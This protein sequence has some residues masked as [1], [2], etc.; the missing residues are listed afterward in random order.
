GECTTQGIGSSNTASIAVPSGGGAGQVSA[1][2]IP[3]NEN[4]VVAPAV[5]GTGTTTALNIDA[6]IQAPKVGTTTPTVV[7]PSTVPK[8]ATTPSS[9]SSVNIPA[10]SPQSPSSVTPPA[11]PS[12]EKIPPLDP[13]P[14]PV[15]PPIAPDPTETP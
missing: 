15:T 7:A 9:N 8:T 3:S 13:S 14:A 12:T 5:S 2:E 10:V 6:P 4:A 11:S 1:P